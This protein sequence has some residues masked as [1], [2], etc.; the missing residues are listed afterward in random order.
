MAKT[1]FT[2]G[3]TKPP[4]KLRKQIDID[5]TWKHFII[6]FIILLC[7]LMFIHFI[8][9]V[10]GFHQEEL[11]FTCTDGTKELIE[12]GR[13]MYCGKHYSAIEGLVSNEEYQKVK[14]VIINGYE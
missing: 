11:F 6:F 5:V 2:F 13:E 3:S 1:T 10:L 12:Q 9:G 4:E 8:L 14:E 7:W